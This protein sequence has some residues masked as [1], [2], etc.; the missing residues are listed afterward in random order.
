MK[1]YDAIKKIVAE[2]ENDVTKFEGGTN[3]A[4]GR[5]RKFCQEIKKA[6]QALRLDV[7]SM[8]EKRKK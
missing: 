3:A 8:K 1:N 4:G 2:M 7:Q 6:C 5:V